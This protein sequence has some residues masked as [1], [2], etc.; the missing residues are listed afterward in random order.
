MSKFPPGSADDIAERVGRHKNTAPTKHI[1]SVMA[2]LQ[3]IVGSGGKIAA[4]A[5]QRH[6]STLVKHVTNWTA[7]SDAAG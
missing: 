4:K 2:V 7:K 1:G 6:I 3:E 5:F